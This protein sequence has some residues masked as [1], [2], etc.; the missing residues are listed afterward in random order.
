MPK[1]NCLVL[2]SGSLNQHRFESCLTKTI[3]LLAAALAETPIRNGVKAKR[4][5]EQV[6]AFRIPT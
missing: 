5:K 1:T 2:D 3:A 6:Y 4:T